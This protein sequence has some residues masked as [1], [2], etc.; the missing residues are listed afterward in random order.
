MGERILAPESAVAFIQ[1]DV[2]K[3]DL[4]GA[5]PEDIQFNFDRIRRVYTYG[6]LCYDLFTVASDQCFFVLEQALGERF[7]SYFGGEIPVPGYGHRGVVRVERFEDL[8][9]QLFGRGMPHRR[10]GWKVESRTG[11]TPIGISIGLRFLLEWAWHEGL[12]PGQRTRRIKNA[13]ASLRDF[14]AHP[15]S[16]KILMPPQAARDIGRTAELI[17]RLWG[18]DTPGGDLFPS[19]LDREPLII[20]WDEA[21]KMKSIHRPRYQEYRPEQAK[22]RAIVV[23]GVAEDEGLFN[24]DAQYERTY[25]PTEYLY[26]ESSLS[27]AFRWV[28]EHVVEGVPAPHADRVFA[29]QTGGV[30]VDRVRLP[31]VMAG[32]PQGRRTGRWHLIR[33]DHPGDAWSH[34]A[35]VARQ[36]HLCA[37]GEY[38]EAGGV[39]PLAD[40]AWAQ[41]VSSAR[42]TGVEVDPTYPP[43]ARVPALGFSWPV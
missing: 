38:C 7:V 23:L 10:G 30:E 31:A 12:L 11:A 16:R 19:P 37:I 41:V 2:A 26:G 35:S 24:Y 20:S 8:R 43:D 9:G 18:V 36:G 15:H 1:A 13:V 40:G 22:W 32:L 25:W 33:A 4:N 5:V 34:A 42:G 6:V 39:T 29:V 28:S 17:N 21:Q 27:D 3:Y 14:A